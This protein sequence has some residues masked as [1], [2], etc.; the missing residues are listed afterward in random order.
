MN[1]LL[2]RTLTGFVYVSIIIGSILLN[3]NAFAIVLLAFVII[4][5][6]E[7]ANLIPPRI[8]PV[9][10]KSNIVIP[11]LSF[12]LIALYSLSY[13]N[14]GIAAI[15]LLLPF[16]ILMVELLKNGKNPIINV[17]LQIF[18]ILY[19]SIPL[20][21][22]L[23][24][25]LPNEITLW[26]RNQL[27]LGLF[28]LIWTNDTGAYIFGSILGKHR[29]YFLISPKK[30]WEGF[31]GGFLLVIAVAY[32]L[33]RFDSKL[34]AID[35]IVLGIIISITST[36]GDLVESMFKRSVNIKDTGNI[37]PGHGGILDRIDALLFSAPFAF[38]YLYLTLNL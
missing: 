24:L 6:I 25:Y 8:I 22:I 17:S 11:A 27:I 2:K 3:I 10:N 36:L 9:P 5:S 34:P 14:K 32:L 26:Q 7:Y 35:W 12:L 13:I 28:I 4:A 15:L 33:S 29:L 21:L 31:I 16:L 37:L 20:G 30:S 19:I 23:F 38:F 18:N 1:E